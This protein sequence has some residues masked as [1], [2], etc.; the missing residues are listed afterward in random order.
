LN[1][2]N[3]NVSKLNLKILKALHLNRSVVPMS[4]TGESTRQATQFELLNFTRSD[5]TQFVE[6][7][8]LLL[9]KK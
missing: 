3:L 9:L 1:A 2:K 8:L 6:I 5:E 4:K 7:L